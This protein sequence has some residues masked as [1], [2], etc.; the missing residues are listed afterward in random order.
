MRLFAQFFC[1]ISIE[2]LKRKCNDSGDC[3]ACTW[4]ATLSFSFFLSFFFFFGVEGGCL[5]DGGVY[6]KKKYSY[7]IARQSSFFMTGLMF[8]CVFL[9]DRGCPTIL[10]TMQVSRSIAIRRY[11]R[12]E[13]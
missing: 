1:F 12:N 13:G 6:F 7:F 3:P 5:S 10:Q 2:V 4:G 11:P 9:R 8:A